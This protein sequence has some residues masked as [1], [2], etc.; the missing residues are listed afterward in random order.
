M[1]GLILEDVRL[2]T[3]ASQALVL[4]GRDVEGNSSLIDQ[5]DA[6]IKEQ[7]IG[8]N[9]IVKAMAD[10]VEASQS[11]R[12][13]ADVQKND[14]EAMRASIAKLV[15]VFDTIRDAT[16]RQAEGN[17]GIIEGVKH[18]EEVA[19]RN[20]EIVGTLEGLLR[21]FVLKGGDNSVVRASV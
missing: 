19:T 21:G 8:A 6:G 7:E 11:I 9:E 20:Q 5:I 2:A 18:L 4:I 1:K 14:S 17:R 10:L 13:T 15:E 16:A 12:A 3:E